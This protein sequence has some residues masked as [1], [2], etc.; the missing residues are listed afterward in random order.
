[1]CFAFSNEKSS[2]SS[3]ANDV[4]NISVTGKGGAEKSIQGGSGSGKCRVQGGSSSE[5]CIFCSKP[6]HKIYNC[7]SFIAAPVEKRCKFATSNNLCFTCLKISHASNRCRFRSSPRAEGCKK[8]HH[9]LLCSCEGETVVKSCVE[10]AL[11]KVSSIVNRVA[12]GVGEV[13]AR[14]HV[15][16]VVVSNERGDEKEVYA[17]LDSG[18][19][20]SLLSKEVADFLELPGVKKDVVV[21]TADGR[22]TPINTLQVKLHVGPLNRAARYDVS[23]VLVM[24][25]LQSIGPNV[26][27]A[28]NLSQHEYLSDL[29]EHFP[30]LADDRLQFII[31]TKETFLTHRTN[32]RKAPT[33]K[34]WAAKTKLGWVVYGPDN[35]VTEK[36][37]TA[38]VSFARV[39]NEMLDR[40][41]DLWLD[42]SFDESRHD[43][44]EV[45]SYDDKRAISLYEQSLT[46]VE[47]HY[48]VALPFKNNEAPSLLNNISSA[49]KQLLSLSRKLSKNPEK[50]NAYC[51]F[52]NELFDNGHAVILSDA[53][54]RG[55]EGRV[56]HLNYHMVTSSGK[57]RIVFNCSSEF[58]GANLNKLLLKGPNLANS[59][60]GVFFRFRLHRY[61]IVGDI[62]KMYYQC[63]VLETD[64][65]FLRFLCFKDDLLS[66]DV[67]HCRMTRLAYGLLCSQS[68]AQFCLRRAISNNETAA[69]PE[70]LELA[71][72]SFYVDDL[73]TSVSASSEL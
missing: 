9:A 1:M 65:D 50:L 37:S 41:L 18:S 48:A 11:K 2:D 57:N 61:A 23:D 69:A 56:W 71:L 51:K 58:A 66:G 29:I 26:P 12:S 22:R 72:H 16:P 42:T 63:C 38:R 30:R 20:E 3:V 6:G 62:K 19:E 15:L 33:G 53:Q 39:T 59:L 52:M 17:M 10:E 34:P 40:K 24:D 36:N 27:C 7:Y 28:E 21:I 68:G 54:A 73:L 70:T 49:R 60:I 64:Q 67:I 32:V 43:D 14:L 13:G 46:R 47:K 5:K 35:A 44:E 45:M 25:N 31:G 55:E 4:N 8:N